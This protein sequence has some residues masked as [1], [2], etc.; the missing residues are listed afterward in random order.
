VSTGE[1]TLATALIVRFAP[2]MLVLA[3]RNFYRYQAWQQLRR[4]ARRCGGGSA[5]P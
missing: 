3:D 2:G 5:R 4:P 1:Q